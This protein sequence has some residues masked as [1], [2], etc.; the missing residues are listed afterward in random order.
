MPSAAGRARS[1]AC[2]SSSR[3]ATT[4]SSTSLVDDVFDWFRWVDATFS[5][6][7]DD[8]EISRLNRGELSLADAH[9]EVVEVAR[10]LRAA[11]ASRPTATSTRDASGDVSTR[12]A[13]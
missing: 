3:C 9:P 11:A 1:W 10:A 4:T 13:S 2:R 6:Y 8:S 5:T 7:K 12:P